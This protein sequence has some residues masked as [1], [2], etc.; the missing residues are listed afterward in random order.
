LGSNHNSRAADGEMVAARG[1]WP[2]LCVSLKHNSKFA[3]FTLVAKGDYPAELNIPL[4][5]SLISNDVTHNKLIVMPGYWFMYNYYALA[6]NSAKYVDR[7]KRTKIIQQIEYNYLAPDSVNEMFDALRLLQRFAAK[8]AGKNGDEASLR[9]EGE[10]VLLDENVNF[11]KLEIYAE[12][13][14]GANR[15]VQIVKAKEAYFLYRELIV[16]YGIEQLVLFVNSHNPVSFEELLEALPALPQRAAFVNVGGQL[17]PALSVQTLLEQVKRD[18][19]KSWNEV[20]RFYQQNGKAYAEQKLQHSF[21]SLLEILNIKKTD[22]TPERFASLLRQALQTK[23]WMTE[24]I[25]DSRAKDYNSEFRKMMYDN[26]AE[27]EKVVGNLEDNV[28]INQQKE[29]LQRFSEQTK[30]IAERFQLAS[31]LSR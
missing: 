19:I 23:R 29:E 20:H 16:F 26:E 3:S 28:F 5:F 18:A 24:S 6:R 11:K 17:L 7:D 13:F 22:F 10:T 2:G 21:A 1:F 12:G 8:A 14:E 9:K 31:S 25:Y 30:E 15:P 27:M 4:P